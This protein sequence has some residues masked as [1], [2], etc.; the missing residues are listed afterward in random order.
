MLKRLCCGPVNITGI[1]LPCHC[2]G[3]QLRWLDLPL[4][5]TADT[6]EL[7]IVLHC[8]W[9]CSIGPCPGL[10]PELVPLLTYLQ[11]PMIDA[12][13]SSSRP[14]FLAGSLHH[15]DLNLR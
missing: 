2:R 7:L 4:A 5:L 15:N 6:L 10:P 11:E 1:A 8:V 14:G 3:T 9:T 12:P 13:E